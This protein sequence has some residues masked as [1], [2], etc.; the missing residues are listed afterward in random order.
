[1]TAET[2][3]RQA[4]FA[5]RFALTGAA[6]PIVL[7]VGVAAASRTWP[8]YR[9]RVQNLSDLGGT[10]APAP[11]LLNTT[12]VLFGLLVV[13]FAVALRAS[14]LDHLSTRVV[15]VLVGSFGATTVVQGLTPCTP[16][17]A[18]GTASDVVHGLAATSGLLAVAVAMGWCW[19]RTRS[20]VEGSFYGA[21]SAW[22]GVLTLG[23]LVAWLVAAGTDPQGLHAGALQ[24]VLV[25]VVLVWLAATAVRFRRGVR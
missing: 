5:R 3:H 22:S 14:G 24:R 16:G 10:A 11:E 25:A 6:A 4:T 13:V 8:G 1:M 7:V 12:L 17:C 23:F 19:R 21:L 18:E 2:S 9:H 15:A 20:S